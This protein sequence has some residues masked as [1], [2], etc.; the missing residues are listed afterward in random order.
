MRA[1][2][3]QEVG[4][5]ADIKHVTI[6]LPRPLYVD[7]CDMRARGEFASIHA[8]VIAD[9]EKRVLAWKKKTKGE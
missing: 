2:I 7:L 6:R 9:L 3:Q 1:K 5:M 4:M 8:A